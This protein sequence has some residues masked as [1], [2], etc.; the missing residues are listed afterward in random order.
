MSNDVDVVVSSTGI[1]R[2]EIGM[3][4]STYHCHDMHG[5]PSSEEIHSNGSVHKDGD[6]MSRTLNWSTRCIQQEKEEMR[7]CDV[8]GENDNKM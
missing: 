8:V 7:D 5:S 3:N 1:S 6:S 4:R 2:L